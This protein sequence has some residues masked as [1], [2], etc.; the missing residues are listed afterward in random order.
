M[1]INNNFSITIFSSYFVPPSVPCHPLSLRLFLSF[2]VLICHAKVL[3][4]PDLWWDSHPF[5]PL[6]CCPMPG[7]TESS[8]FSFY[9]DP[10]GVIS[11][12]PPL[13]NLAGHRGLGETAE[14]LGPLSGDPAAPPPRPTQGSTWDMKPRTHWLMSC[15]FWGFTTH[16]PF[17]FQS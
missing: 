11:F 1:Y 2:K 12:V 8:P 14:A 13:A 3:G 7:A 4:A 15:T 6:N 10:S 17:I 5:T 16:H 9:K